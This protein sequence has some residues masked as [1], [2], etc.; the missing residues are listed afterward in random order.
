MNDIAIY[1]SYWD[2]PNSCK[3]LTVFV[4]GTD[5]TDYGDDDMFDRTSSQFDI[6]C[7]S[8][9][10]DS[11]SQIRHASILFTSNCVYFDGL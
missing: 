7:D 9:D 4:I 6:S 5:T 10:L 3:F 11:V 1:L 2:C 8:F